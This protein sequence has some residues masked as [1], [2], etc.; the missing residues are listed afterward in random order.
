MSNKNRIFCQLDSVI[1]LFLSLLMVCDILTTLCLDLSLSVLLMFVPAIAWWLYS[2]DILRPHT[3]FF[4]YIT[5][6]DI[7]IYTI[8]WP[9]LF[10]LTHKYHWTWWPVTLRSFSFFF[11]VDFFFIFFCCCCTCKSTV[12]GRSYQNTYFFFKF[13]FQLFSITWWIPNEVFKQKNNKMNFFDCKLIHRD[14]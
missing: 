5:I 12:F 14:E 11:V 2:L 10:L 13:V 9:L 4:N 3:T 8:R 7:L 1:S 6:T